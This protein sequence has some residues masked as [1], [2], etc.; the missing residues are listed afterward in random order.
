MGNTATMYVGEW[1]NEVE[2]EAEED[3]STVEQSSTVDDMG[4]GWAVELSDEDT[5]D[6]VLDV[7]IYNSIFNLHHQCELRESLVRCCYCCCFYVHFPALCCCR[8]THTH[9]YV[10]IGWDGG[11]HQHHHPHTKL[12]TKLRL[13]C[14]ADWFR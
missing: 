7:K 6:V 4:G 14:T 3:G 12:N 9:M 13:R 5:N 8:T 2:R 11:A 1:A 10:H